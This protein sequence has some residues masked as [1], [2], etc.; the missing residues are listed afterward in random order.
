MTET[1]NKK[2]KKNSFYNKESIKIQIEAFVKQLNWDYLWLQATGY[3]ISF[4][5]FIVKTPKQEVHRSKYL[6]LLL[7]D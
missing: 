6:N 5:L 4:K 3:K 2:K 7:W 1:C